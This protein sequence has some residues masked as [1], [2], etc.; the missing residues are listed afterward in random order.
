MQLNATLEYVDSLFPVEVV[1]SDESGDA[2]FKI[3]KPVLVVT[4]VI[5]SPSVPVTLMNHNLRLDRLSPT[6]FRNLKSFWKDSLVIPNSTT[7][8]G[9]HQV[10]T[11][12]VSPFQVGIS[13]VGITQVGITQ[14][15]I[16]Q[17]G[18][19]QIGICQVSPTQVCMYQVS[20]TQVA[21]P[22]VGFTQVGSRFYS[23][24]LTISACD[25]HL[26]PSNNVVTVHFQIIDQEAIEPC[27]ELAVCQAVEQV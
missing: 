1:I 4:T 19:V 17:I 8:V 2:P 22:Q 13:Q 6:L 21:P 15:G 3:L 26:Q 9:S 5:S 7:Q 25:F 14:V 10:G 18:L 20:L 16:H 23:I 24:L 12:Q 11:T 27:F